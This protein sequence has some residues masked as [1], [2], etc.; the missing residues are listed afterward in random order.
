MRAHRLLGAGRGDGSV[1][2]DGVA[3]GVTNM[4]M[5][6]RA[7]VPEKG[8][9]P[10]PLT[11]D[12]AYLRTAIVNVYLYGTPGQDDRSWVLIDAGMPGSAG[13]IIEAASRRFGRGSRPAA[14][15]LTHGHFDHV[16]AVRELAE[17]WD[18]PVY[19][20][21]LEFPYLSGRS[22]YPPPDPTVGGGAMASLSWLYP[23]GPIDLG[24]RLRPLPEDGSVPAMPDW[25]WIF[26]P[27]HAPG[28][29]SLFR[30][31]DRTLIAGDA[32]ITTKQESAFAVLAQRPEIHGPPRY[33]TPDWEAAHRSVETLAALEPELA[34]TGHGIPLS[35]KVMRSALHLLAREFD[36]RA[37]PTHGRYV[38]RPA[39]TGPEGIISLP[40]DVPHVMPAILLGVGAGLLAGLALRRNSRRA[41]AD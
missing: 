25:R 14:I 17:E 16:G 18:V 6:A 11:D 36:R 40:P 3:T 23:R 21:P 27:G 22:P 4:S 39:M 37:V 31:A 5:T 8:S 24:G 20:H 30:D 35:G 7:V 26:T 33:F 9:E 1:A 41:R 2:G 15:L 34:A 19:A 38:S 10:Y 32:F 28:H 13:R 29:I 12:L